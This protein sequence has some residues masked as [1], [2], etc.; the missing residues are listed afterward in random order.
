MSDV[1]CNVLARDCRRAGRPD[2]AEGFAL[3]A[4][5]IGKALGNAQVV[6]IN[7]TTLGNIRRDQGRSTDALLEYHR[8]TEA[9]VAG[10]HRD[11]EASAT[12]LIASVHNDQGE[13]G[14]ALPY[15]QHA[16]ALARLI[17]DQ[18]LVARAEEER[19][20]AHAGLNELQEA[21]AAYAAAARAI[22]VNRRGGAAFV[23]LVVDGLRLCATANRPELSAELLSGVFL[24][25]E[26]S[27][28]EQDDPI[29]IWYRALSRVAD[30]VSAVEHVLAIVALAANNSPK[31]RRPY[32][33][34]R[35]R[36]EQR[37]DRSLGP[38]RF[39]DEVGDIP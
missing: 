34:G 17:G 31:L 25:F 32:I 20:R 24:E 33:L 22:A 38:N 19:A 29:S 23:Q 30:D 2:Q 12:E 21:V 4:L 15:A 14:L 39:A 5:R 10:T 37:D 16:G 3:E 6:A 13:H 26:G 8:A 1:M 18:E 27:S 28:T 11:S 7:R 35:T 36:T 9:A